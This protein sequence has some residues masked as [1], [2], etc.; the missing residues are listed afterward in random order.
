MGTESLTSHEKII[1]S[2]F[3]IKYTN[4]AKSIKLII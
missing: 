1:Y 2:N 3:K 4:I